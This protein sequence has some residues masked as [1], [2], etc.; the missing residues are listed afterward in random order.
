MRI[1]SILSLF[2]ALFAG[3]SLY[4]QEQDSIRSRKLSEVE[5]SAQSKPPTALSA[6]PLQVI[7]SKTIAEQG[8]YS[9]SDAIKRFNG[10]VLK[11]Y[12][13]IGGLKTI[14]IRGMGAEYTAISYDGVII[15]N[16]Q[17]GQVDIGR[18]SLDN[19]SAISLNIGQAND[20]FQ[21]A[22]SFSSAGVLNL[23]TIQPD[24]QKQNY[25]GHMKV[26]TGSF[27]LFNPAVTYGQKINNT[28]SISANG[29]WQRADGNYPFTKKEDKILTDRKRENSD[30]D[31]LRTEVNLYSD[32]GKQ[33][34]LN[35]KVYYFD[36]ERGLPGNVVL[37]NDY[38]K[39]RL[40]D[41]DFFT[42][43]FYSVSL[44]NKLKLKSR[45]KYGQ[46]RT[47]Y[48]DTHDKYGDS[49]K[50][51]NKYKEKDAYLSNSILY[52]L[53][54]KI[55]FSLAED[56]SFG[57][58]DK[59]MQNGK[60]DSSPERYISYTALAGKYQSQRIII[61]SSLLATYIDEK[62]KGKNDNIYKKLS[63]A[64]I[65][66][67][68]PFSETSLRV[69][70]SYKQTY[71]VPTFTELYYSSIEKKLKPESAK[72]YNLGITW[73]GSIASEI[74]PYLNIS[75]DG[76]YNKVDDKIVIIP[77]TFDATA[78]NMDVDIKGIDVKLSS[79]IHIN[80][81]MNINFVTTYSLMQALDM[82]GLSTESYK[83]QIPYTPLHSGAATL[84]LNNPWVIFSY[85]A[86][87][88]GKR[89][90]RPVNEKDS[91]IDG[92]TDHSI[93]LFKRIKANNN[94]LYMQ[95]SIQNLWNK[96]YDVIANYPMPGRSF[97]LS[98]GYK[99]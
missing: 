35:A 46:T 87:A 32:F 30:V 36:S 67:F 25:T 56:L 61:T 15:N 34:Q 18:F 55:S 98:A 51:E 62:V 1:L 4:A 54:E 66:S 31:I 27:G 88:S 59:D 91:R 82:G 81:E 90:I 74:V 47:K 71:R 89:Y 37:G 6:T 79:N 42:Q 53:N 19:V 41:K 80:K 11:D 99:F 78:L 85:S 8:L 10:V 70:S 9:I 57:K 33:G 65:V 96:N 50:L 17:S 21:S 48:R 24:F 14:S 7:S 76:Y 2:F 75:V 29:N 40:W 38:A 39:E 84:T 63:P 28:F 72:Q 13:G 58:L 45:A 44:N 5:I 69:R 22:K 94:E 16:M 68:Q 92:Y 23:E 64:I 49:G 77:K 60:T 97:L 83:D 73:V 52:S 26:A 95:G 20:I 43:L 93:S 3:V 12:G 86:I